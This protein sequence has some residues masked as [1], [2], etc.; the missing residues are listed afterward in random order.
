VSAIFTYHD[1][2]FK[3][4]EQNIMT[5]GYPKAN[6]SERILKIEHKGIERLFSTKFNLKTK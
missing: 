1:L 6:D 5:L 3:D 4:F 2:S